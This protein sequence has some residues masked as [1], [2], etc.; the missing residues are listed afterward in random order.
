MNTGLGRATFT[1]QGE[2]GVWLGVDRVVRAQGL[3]LVGGDSGVGTLK[4]ERKQRR[5]LS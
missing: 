1:V 2:S 5:C 4:F 3:W